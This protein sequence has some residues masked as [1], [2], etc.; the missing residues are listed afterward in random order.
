MLTQRTSRSH[1]PTGVFLTEASQVCRNGPKASWG[2]LLS[3]PQGRRPH[4]PHRPTAQLFSP[5]ARP[6]N[7]RCPQDP[8]SPRDVRQH[9]PPGQPCARRTRSHAGCRS[10]SRILGSRKLSPSL[11]ER[12]PGC[13]PATFS[14][15]TGSSGVGDGSLGQPPLPPVPSEH[16]TTLPQPPRPWSAR[17]GP[18][19]HRRQAA[20]G[21]EPFPKGQRWLRA[22]EEHQTSGQSSDLGR[23]GGGGRQT[24]FLPWREARILTAGGKAPVAMAWS[25]FSW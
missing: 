18:G 11:E 9:S 13:A 25:Q 2:G 15:T 3:S 6:E 20:Q 10:T 12:E 1:L 21:I 19:P 24:R 22:Q 7:V 8:R 5:T 4:L 14:K 17:T 23:N 16:V